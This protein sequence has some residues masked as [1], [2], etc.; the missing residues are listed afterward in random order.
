[1][2]AEGMGCGV[3]EI[4]YFLMSVTPF[5]SEDSTKLVLAALISLSIEGSPVSQPLQERSIRL[6]I[7]LKIR[8]LLCILHRTHI[9][10]D[11]LTCHT[12]IIIPTR[13]A[14]GLRHTVQSIQRFLIIAVIDIISRRPLLVAFTGRLLRPPLVGISLPLVKKITKCA[15]TAVIGIASLL[16]VI[17]VTA[18]VI[19]LTRTSISLPIASG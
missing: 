15:I 5:A 18:L 6:V 8:R 10:A 11:A 3:L 19:G 4:L 9:I 13:A 12:G 7:R 14:G 17:A 1:M 16:L 2:R